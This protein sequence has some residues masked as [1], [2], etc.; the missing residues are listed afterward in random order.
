MS[1]T[2]SSIGTLI[3]TLTPV[4]NLL[5]KISNAVTVIDHDTYEG[6]YTV[7]PSTTQ[8][9][10]IECA[11]KVMEADVTVLKIPYYET[12]N[13]ANGYTVYIG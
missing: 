5:G 13:V 12:T 11:D 7:T 8:E 2:L 1:N 6:S 3:G 9:Q 10:V 4:G